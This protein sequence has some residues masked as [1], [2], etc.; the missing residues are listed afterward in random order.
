ML[1]TLPTIPSTSIIEYTKV[2]KHTDLNVSAA[3]ARVLIMGLPYNYVVCGASIRCMTQFAGPSLTSLTCSIGAFT[4]DSI[5]TDLT[6]YMSAIEL[7]QPVTPQAF[8]TSGYLSNDL[9]ATPVSPIVGLYLNGAHDVAAY[10]VASGAI[11]NTLSAGIVELAVQ[12]RP[13]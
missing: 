8:A 13:M 11:L 5:L 6:Y 3:T 4:P 2:I 1:T 10:V 12:I 7:T 9:N